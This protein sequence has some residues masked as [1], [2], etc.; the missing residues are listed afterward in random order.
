MFT[1]LLTKEFFPFVVSMEV[2]ERIIRTVNMMNTHVPPWDHADHIRSAV[3]SRSRRG[4]YKMK[5]TQ[6]TWSSV[7]ATLEGT[8]NRGLVFITHGGVDAALP[9]PKSIGDILYYEAK[10]NPYAGGDGPCLATRVAS[11]RTDAIATDLIVESFSKN[12]QGLGEALTR[13]LFDIAVFYN[14]NQAL[15]SIFKN[16]KTSD[17]WCARSMFTAMYGA[18]M[19]DTIVHFVD[20]YGPSV[21]IIEGALYSIH[22]ADD[23]ELFKRIWEIAQKADDA[24]D[25]ASFCYQLASG[26]LSEVYPPRIARWLIGKS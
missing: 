11:C 23:L 2:S 20:L 12:E 19:C 8:K 15:I 17:L 13:Q 18:G 5:A 1:E 6:A 10:D 26:A 7:L 24:E 9:S 16:A 4:L 3:D 25:Y 14:W 21:A 22:L